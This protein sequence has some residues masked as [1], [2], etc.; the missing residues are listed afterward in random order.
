M[1]YKDDIL[2]NIYDSKINDINTKISDLA[3]IAI[4]NTDSE[5]EGNYFFFIII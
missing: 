5:I 3:I 1:S 4:N 2:I